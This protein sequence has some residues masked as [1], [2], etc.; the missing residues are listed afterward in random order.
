MLSEK[1]GR[2][3]PMNKN[4]YETIG[5]R[6]DATTEQIEAACLRLGEQYRDR[7][8]LTDAAEKFA[9]VER[10]YEM[11]ADP[12]CRAAYDRSIDT[13]HTWLGVL[14]KYGRHVRSNWTW[15]SIDLH[16]QKRASAPAEPLDLVIMRWIK[17]GAGVF[18][19]MVLILILLSR[20]PA[21]E[22]EAARQAQLRQDEQRQAEYLR[23]FMERNPNGPEARAV[24]KGVAESV[25]RNDRANGR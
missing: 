20:G 3:G 12:V 4:L 1:S 5:V 25:H 11:L 19:L 23:Q 22:R 18:S 17:I 9:E 24:Y 16:E 14:A 15:V 10:A 8:N 13:L 2:P 6:P 21:A 7:Q